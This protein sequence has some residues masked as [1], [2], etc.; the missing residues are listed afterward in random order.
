[1]S[2][3]AFLTFF[4]AFS[5]DV[6]PSRSSDGVPPGVL[7]D[8]VE[9][10]DGDEH[11]VVAVIAQLEKLLDDVAV[12]DRQLLQADELPDAVIDVD[13]VVADLEIAQVGEE[14]RRQ[15][16]LA[17]RRRPPRAPPRRRRFRR[18]PAAPPRAA[19][20]RCD[21][22][23]SA[24]STA[25]STRSSALAGE[26]RA[27]VVVVQQF[28]GA[29]G[30]AVRAG[31]EQD[32]FAA[33]ARLP[34]VGDPVGDAAAKLLRRLRRDMC[35]ALAAAIVDAASSSSATALTSRRFES[36]QRASSSAGG[37]RSRSPGV[38]S[39]WR[40][41]N[42]AWTCSVHLSICARTSSRLGDDH[43]HRARRAEI[44]E[45]AAGSAGVRG[46]P[47]REDSPVAPESARRRLP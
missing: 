41:S 38:L 20:T 19:G 13:D 24:T 1:M 33:L 9:P 34:D 39:L 42:E 14:R 29:L 5:Q 31:D 21:S 40:S 18:R 26:E 15:R 10:L 11:L 3:M 35:G 23:P 12:A 30:A 2:R 27:D 32:R 28:H 45:D 46:A 36:A 37:R 43:A 8:Q 6:P 22:S 17:A 4:F 7:L 44:V 16:S 47:Q 25:P